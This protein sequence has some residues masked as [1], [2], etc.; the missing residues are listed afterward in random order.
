MEPT[1]QLLPCK[2][3]GGKRRKTA[4]LIIVVYGT[5]EHECLESEL[6]GNL[7]LQLGHSAVSFVI[8]RGSK[9]RFIVH[10]LPISAYPPG[11]DQ[12]TEK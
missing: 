4:Q 9:N 12:G 2:E 6:Q 8:T 7:C 5:F 11:A 10:S 1:T 3:E